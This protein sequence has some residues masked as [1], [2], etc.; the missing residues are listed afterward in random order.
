MKGN[1]FTEVIVDHTS[2][3]IKKAE[4]ITDADDVK[5]VQ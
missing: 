5:D 4:P 1:H 2:G 3:S